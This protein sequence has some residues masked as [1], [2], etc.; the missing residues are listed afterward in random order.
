M[1]FS[2]RRLR[3]DDEQPDITNGDLEVVGER[4][5]DVRGVVSWAL[6][7]VTADEPWY[8]GI[9]ECQLLVE[10]AGDRR[11]RGRAALIRSD[12]GRWHY[13]KGAG[14]LEGLEFAAFDPQPD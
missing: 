8:P 5:G 14:N 6:T 13:F 7:L 3:V 11:L 12:R 4:R 9:G 10:V 1:H 2:V